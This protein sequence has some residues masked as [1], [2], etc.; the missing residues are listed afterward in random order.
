MTI[1]GVVTGQG[2]MPPSIVD[3]DTPMFAYME[4]VECGSGAVVKLKMT[5]NNT[6]IVQVMLTNGDLLTLVEG[7][8][9]GEALNIKRYGPIYAVDGD[10]S[11]DT[12]DERVSS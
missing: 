12:Y 10:K 9:A 11:E 5:Q 7:A 1:K 3:S 2:I 8:V 6:F 4:H